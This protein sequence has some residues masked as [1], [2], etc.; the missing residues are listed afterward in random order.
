MPKLLSK[1]N[2]IWN[3]NLKNIHP[4]YKNFPIKFIHATI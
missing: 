4:H 1:N 3:F 2:Y